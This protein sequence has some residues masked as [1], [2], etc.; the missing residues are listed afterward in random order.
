VAEDRVLIQYNHFP[1][2]MAGERSRGHRLKVLPLSWFYG[3]GD[4][5]SE[6]P[7]L[8]RI[9]GHVRGEI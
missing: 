4:P 9:E 2:D 3:G 5:T 6:N 1:L 8:D 7:T